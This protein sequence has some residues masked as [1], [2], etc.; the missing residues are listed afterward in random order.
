M[1]RT[2]RQKV[3]LKRWL[4]AGGKAS[5]EACTGFGK[6]RVALNL[7]DAFTAKNPEAQTLIVVPTQFLKDQWIQHVDERGLGF[8]AR[9]EII[10]S[11]IKLDWTCDL[12]I[13]DECHLA[14]AETFANVFKCVSYKFILCL[15]GTMERLDMRHLLIERF[16]PICDKITIEEA[17]ANGWVSPHKEY[18]VL[19]NVDLT[20]YNEWT[21]KFNSYFSYMDYDFGLA[22]RLATNPIERNAWSKKMGLDARKTAAIAMDWMRMMK[23]RKD[24]VMNHPKKLEVARRILNARPDKKAITFSATIK[25]AEDIGIG[26]TVHS[27]KRAKE[28]KKILE[29]FNNATYGVLNTSKSADQ[30]LDLHGINLEVILHTDSSKIR[31]VQRVGRSIR[32]EEGKTTEIFTLVIA[33]T[34][35]IKWL[36]NSRA[37]KVITINEEQLDRILAGEDVKTRERNYSQDLAFR[38]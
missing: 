9:V 32:F 26:Y 22:M 33:G 6:T 19:L 29:E 14:A 11:V 10:N 8:N 24:F 15:T 5:I 28:N 30:G 37:S 36:A 34:Q 35:E 38:F 1:D 18:V 17:E 12:L 27:Q 16:A 3:C 31:K 2:E 23:K 20:E 7:V 13:I 21:R 4:T 25:M